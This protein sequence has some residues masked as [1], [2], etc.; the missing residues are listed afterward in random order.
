MALHFDLSTVRKRLGEDDFEFYT[1]HPGDYG[2]DEKRWHPVSD[3]LVWLS[4]SC[5]YGEITEANVL[6]VAARIATFE[7]KHGPTFMTAKGRFGMTVEDV[8]RHIG[9]A[10]N[11]ST[12]T[13]AQFARSF[14]PLY[15]PNFGRS[16]HSHVAETCSEAS[17]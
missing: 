6:Q 16:A 5:G 7:A 3:A 9:L 17:Q 15:A 14:G 11:A 4:M 8:W 1:T 2:K 10:T 13:K 12:L